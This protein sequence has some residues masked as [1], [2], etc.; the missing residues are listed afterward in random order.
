MITIKKNVICFILGA[1]IFGSIS[2]VIAYSF[3][4]SD[5]K[6]EPSDTNWKTY[7]E[8]DIDDVKKL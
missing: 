8:N 3:G 7:E 4:A 6:Y 2:S 1:I 5:V